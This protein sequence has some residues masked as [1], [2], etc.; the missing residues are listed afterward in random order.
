MLCVTVTSYMNLWVQFVSVCI[1]LYQYDL[2]TKLC[3][4]CF[5]VSVEP[6][7]LAMHRE[8]RVRNP[9]MTWM[10][11]SFFGDISFDTCLTH[12]C[13]LTCFDIHL[14]HVWDEMQADSSAK[15]SLN[16]FHRFPSVSSRFLLQ[17]L[18]HLRALACWSCCRFTF[19][20]RSWTLEP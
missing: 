9:D 7:L 5:S 16:I 19:L 17:F 6:G 14:T 12:M 10:T 2:S 4:F 20:R 11:T 13:F 18:K 3:G 8:M 1:G 15:P